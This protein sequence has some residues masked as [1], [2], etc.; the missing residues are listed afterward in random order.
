MLVTSKLAVVILFIFFSCKQVASGT[1]KEMQIVNIKDTITIEMP[2]SL[3]SGSQW[4][5]LDST[6]V[7]VL[8]HEAR[9]GPE[10]AALPDIEVYK[11]KF[12]RTGIYRI[13]FYY[14]RPFDALSDTVF[15][16]KINKLIKV[17]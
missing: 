7:N 3:G 12:L 11:I 1:K 16:K 9:S 15:A 13:T 10:N 6:G 5:L 8:S 2:S 4:M 14:R 17:K